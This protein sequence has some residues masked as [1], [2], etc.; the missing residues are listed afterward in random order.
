MGDHCYHDN[1]SD[2]DPYRSDVGSRDIFNIED[3]IFIG[4]VTMQKFHDRHSDEV[5][6]SR[7]GTVATVTEIGV[8]C[9]VFSCQPLHPGDSL[10]VKVEKSSFV[11]IKPVV[12]CIKLEYLYMLYI[13][14]KVD[15]TELSYLVSINLELPVLYRISLS[16]KPGLQWVVNTYN[17][18]LLSDINC[19][20]QLW[21]NSLYYIS[22]TVFVVWLFMFVI[23][24]DG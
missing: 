1:M 10:T 23:S 8:D 17:V 19:V 21:S 16:Y 4:Q 22:H 6:L 20:Y 12:T 11:S 3:L 15:Q 2:P 18:I 24:A 5:T 14:V 9:E 13:T 7:G